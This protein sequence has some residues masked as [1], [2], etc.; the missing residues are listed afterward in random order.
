M[1]RP[2]ALALASLVVASIAF[3]DCKPSAGASCTENAAV[4]NSPTSHMACV[5]GHYVEETCKGPNG[6]KEANGKATCDTTKGDIGDPCASANMG[7]C[8]TDG[9]TK[10]RCDTGKLVFVSRCSKDGCTTDDNNNAHCNDP[11]DRI[12]DDCKIDATRSERANGACN[13]DFK[14]E[15]RCK[16]GKMALTHQC[17]GEQGCVPLSSGPWCDRSIGEAGDECDPDKQEFAVACDA[18]KEKMYVCKSHKLAS[19]VRCG[20]EGKCYVRQY[21]Q[22]GFSHYQAECDQS[23][24]AIGDDCVKEGQ[25]ACS[26]DLKNKLMC[27]NGKFVLDTACKKGC[28]VRAPDGTPFTC[29]ENAEHS[30]G[31]NAGKK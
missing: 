19:P 26:D 21:G 16:D 18:S 28:M 24:G 10:L 23:L 14:S 30:P 9:K 1:K 29:K 31:A 8:G 27:Q 15:L 2:L 6:C 17:R 12:G 13:E 22:D 25:G 11:F 5:T 20:G 4:C 3:V 7:V